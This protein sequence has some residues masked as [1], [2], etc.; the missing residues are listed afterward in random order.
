M[1]I[2]PFRDFASFDQEVQLDDIP[3]RIKFDYNVRYGF[4]TMSFDTR[5]SI[6]IISGI[7]LVLNYQLLEQYQGRGGLPNGELYVIDTTEEET[8][9]NRNNI[10]EP[11][12]IVYIPE[13]ELA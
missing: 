1:V 6:P 3:Y 13:D 12:A 7:K 5:D 11:L 4:W 10:I 9:I 2:V 8:K